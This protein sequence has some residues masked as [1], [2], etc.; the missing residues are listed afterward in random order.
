MKGITNEFTNT[1]DLEFLEGDTDNVRRRRLASPA[2]I[3]Y[4]VLKD[5]KKDGCSA[6][7]NGPHMTKVTFIELRI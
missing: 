4:V 3:V 6:P 7:D 1:L 2:A 5:M